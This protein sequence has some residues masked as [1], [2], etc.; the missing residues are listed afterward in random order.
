MSNRIGNPPQ[1]VT[2]PVWAWYKFNKEH[3]PLDLRYRGYSK[4]G[5]K[6]VCIELEVPDNEVVLTDYDAWHFV[7][8]KWYLNIDCEDEETWDKDHEWLDSLEPQVKAQE[9]E[10]SWQSVFRIDEYESDWQ[11]RGHFV[12]ATFWILKKEQIKKVRFF[13]A[14]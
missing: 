5:D 4:R 8:N 3:K 7:L 10:K 9:I 11:K 6:C 2:Y 14:K 1:S 13:T 12:Q